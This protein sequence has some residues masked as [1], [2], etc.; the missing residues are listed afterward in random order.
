MG[1]IITVL[2]ASFFTCAV[3]V[4]AD[5][6]TAH[7]GTV[8]A[9]LTFEHVSGS[10]AINLQ[11]VSIAR[12]SAR[13]FDGAL[14]SGFRSAYENALPGQPL[15]AARA[16]N[17]DSEPDI[18]VS[19]YSGGA[20]CCFGV[21][22]YGY[23][24]RA[25]A[26]RAVAHDFGDSGYRFA[27]LGD[28]SQPQFLSADVRF[29]Y[30]FTNFAASALPIQ[31]WR[32]SAGDLIEVTRCYPSLIE[33]DAKTNWTAAVSNARTGEPVTGALAAYAADQYMLGAGQLA[34]KRIMKTGYHGVNDDYA[35]QLAAFLTNNG[36][37][38]PAG[39]SCGALARE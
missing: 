26:Y 31:I 12:G 37:V 39:P 35:E 16:L 8:R 14:P 2:L 32:Y 29:A 13:L 24:R 27:Q 3:P 20:H 25:N 34:I 5:E 15:L 17:A 30:A 36:Y 9:V 10:K 18:V 28:I 22:I 21:V 6:V 19:T 38:G 1:R 7:S 23:D 33:A 11:R 4:L